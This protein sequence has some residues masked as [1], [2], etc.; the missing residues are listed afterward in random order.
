MVRAL[1]KQ[2][3]IDRKY[4]SELVDDAVAN[5]SKYGDFEW[6]ISNDPT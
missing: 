5:I 1:E 4:Y 2:D 3:D 6:F